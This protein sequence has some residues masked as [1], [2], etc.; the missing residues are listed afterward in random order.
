MI[1]KQN[2]KKAVERSYPWTL[3]L[4]K[5]KILIVGLQKVNNHEKGG[6]SAINKVLWSWRIA[7]TYSIIGR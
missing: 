3:A 2:S 1:L 4:I 5:L 6:L 7:V